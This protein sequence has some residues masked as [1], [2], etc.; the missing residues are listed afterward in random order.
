ME[1]IQEEQSQGDED[2]E[3]NQK[4]SIQAAKSEV[5]S[6]ARTAVHSRTNNTV[7]LKDG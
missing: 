7:I 1:E 3:A 5:K 2:D 4:G 6:R